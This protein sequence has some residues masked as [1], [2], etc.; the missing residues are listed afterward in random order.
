MRSRQR[1]ICYVYETVD[2]FHEPFVPTFR[3]KIR[4]VMAIVIVFLC[5]IYTLVIVLSLQE[6]PLRYNYY[7]LTNDTIFCNIYACK[8]VDV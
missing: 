7:C 5:A 4:T 8:S 6:E 3:A 1:H 2:I